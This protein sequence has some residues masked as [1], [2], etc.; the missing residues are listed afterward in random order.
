[1][2][3][4]MALDPEVK[5]GTSVMMFGGTSDSGHGTY[6]IMVIAQCHPWTCDGQCM[7]LRAWHEIHAC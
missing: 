7:W 6:E 1:M 5:K 4:D 3:Q 2:G